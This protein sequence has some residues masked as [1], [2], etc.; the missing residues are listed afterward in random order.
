VLTIHGTVTGSLA[1]P[2][3]GTGQQAA[4][5]DCAG[6]QCGLFGTLPCQFTVSFAIRKR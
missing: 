6:T 2:S 5:I 4:T 3:H 1:D